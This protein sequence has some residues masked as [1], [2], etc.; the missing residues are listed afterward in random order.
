M[1]SDINYMKINPINKRAFTLF[2]TENK[3]AMA[4]YPLLLYIYK[5]FWSHN[6]YFKMVFE[7][8]TIL[9]QIQLYAVQMTTQ[10]REAAYK[11]PL[12]KTACNVPLVPQ[13]Q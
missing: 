7:N 10:L 6:T 4:Q 1:W 2:P 13:L 8:K 5:Y 12:S 9:N 11:V 3:I